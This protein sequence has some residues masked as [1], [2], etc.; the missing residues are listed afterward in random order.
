MEDKSF[1][2]IIFWGKNLNLVW[3][4][5]RKWNFKDDSKVCVCFFFIVDTITGWLQR[6]RN[7]LKILNVCCMQYLFLVSPQV[8]LTITLIIQI[9]INN[10]QLRMVLEKLLLEIIALWLKVQ[11][12]AT[13]SKFLYAI[14]IMSQ[15]FIGKEK[16][17]KD[18]CQIFLIHFRSIFLFVSSFLIIFD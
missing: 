10:F 15:C 17:G 4:G 5:G 8:C 7:K 9:Y 18:E 13:R 1:N 12:S 6:F 16:W 2:K 14:I 3:I 11:L